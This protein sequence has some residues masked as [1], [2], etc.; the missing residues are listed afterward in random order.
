ML[1]CGGR[2]HNAPLSKT[3]KFP[4]LLPPKHILISLVIHSV[5]LQLFHAGTNATL[6]AIWQRF[7][8]PTARQWIKSQLRHC[9]ICRKHS[10][11]CPRPST[12]T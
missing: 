10:V 12:P 3:A 6:T 11:C 5:H 1:H 8:I 7:W 9:V 2:I 4:I